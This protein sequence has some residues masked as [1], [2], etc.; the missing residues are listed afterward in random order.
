MVA[1]RGSVCLA[2]LAVAGGM[3]LIPDV[4]LAKDLNCSD[5]TYQE[6]AQAELNNDPS[7]PYRLDGDHDGIACETLPH[8][9]T[10]TQASTTTEDTSTQPVPAQS[11]PAQRPAETRHTA[12]SSQTRSSSRDNNGQVKVHPHGGVDTGGWPSA[13]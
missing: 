12:P 7:D 2:S 8:R 13:L 11:T 4:A 10:T 1:S 9:G 5:F 6:D 3:L